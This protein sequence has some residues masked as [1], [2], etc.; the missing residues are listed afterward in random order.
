MA[1]DLAP[2]IDLDHVLPR[3]PPEVFLIH[4]F[5]SGLSDVVVQQIAQR[6]E[7]QVL[8]SVQLSDVAQQVGQARTIEVVTGAVGDNADPGHLR[9]VLGEEPIS[10]SA[11]ILLEDE[12]LKGLA[13]V[14]CDLVLDRR[15]RQAAAA[16]QARYDRS[17]IATMLRQIDGY[18]GQRGDGT[19]GY[20]L[21]PVAVEENAARRKD[22]LLPD[23]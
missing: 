1:D 7:A 22:H 20:Q 6:I 16:A 4:V 23:A 12:R 19:V 9:E 8:L 11:E 17:P 21:G 10:V 18:D 2:R 3:R 5:Q 15:L 14:S 13:G